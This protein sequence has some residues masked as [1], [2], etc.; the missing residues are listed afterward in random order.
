MNFTRFIVKQYSNLLLTCFTILI[1]FTI[2]SC[3]S[4]EDTKSDSE[5]I[6]PDSNFVDYSNNRI[7]VVQSYHAE[8]GGVIIKNK[9]I[10][11]ILDKIDID[12]KIIY[13]DTRRNP[14]EEFKLESALNATRVIAEYEP[15]VVITFDDNAFK[16]L[17]MEHY[18]DADL[19]VVFAGIDWDAS[20][21]GAPY[22]NTV[23]LI[24]VD[25]VI[26]L[27]KY[28]EEY[29]NGDRVAW[30]GVNTPTSEKIIDA[31]KTILGIEFDVHFV[32]SLTEWK[33]TFLELQTS[34][35]VLIHSGTLDSLSDWNLEEAES[36][37]FE[38]IKIPIGTVNENS[39]SISVVGLTKKSGEVQGEW[40]ANTALDILAGT[41]PSDIP[42][43]YNKRGDVELNLELAEQLDISFSPD[44]LKVAEIHER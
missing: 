35:D 14:S 25:L 5:I 6:V 44:L 30:L 34:Y 31:Y 32:S 40:A 15:D 23:G 37:V 33:S 22:S 1:I 41:N 28:L 3:V 36:F 16:Y 7:L 39:I 29:S 8:V 12:Y 43:A 9:G 17:I 38:N 10:S 2:S 42:L 18:K 27:L 24:S 21:Y 4:T 20:V 19:P 11:N 26:Q 13:L